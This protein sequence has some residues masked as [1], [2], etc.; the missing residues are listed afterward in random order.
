MCWLTIARRR[1]D[2]G[3]PGSWILA[4]DSRTSFRRV[5]FPE[6]SSPKTISTERDHLQSI[7]C[8][9]PTNIASQRGDD[10]QINVANGKLRPLRFK[11]PERLCGVHGSQFAVRSWR[12]RPTRGWARC[13]LSRKAVVWPQRRT[14][15]RE[16][17]L[18]PVAPNS[19]VSSELVFS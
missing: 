13:P 4:P 11:P 15:N 1:P 18:K 5:R 17:F 19:L 16:L 12:Q 8:G 7:R 6:T 10:P 3:P 9:G 14:A 2:P